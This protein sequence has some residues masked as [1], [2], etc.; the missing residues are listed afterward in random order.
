MVEK[1]QIYKCSVCGNIVEV[2]NVGSGVLVCCGK[3]MELQEP[4]AKDT[5]GKEKHVPVIEKTESGYKIK[6]G[7]VPHPMEAA[8]YIQWVEILA[9]G[10]SYKTFLQPGQSPDAEFCLEAEKITTRIYCNIHGL[11]QN[12]N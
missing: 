6:V 10:Q 5:E 7:S 11:W 3:D 8:H 9:N 2:V 1:T 4:K 12:N